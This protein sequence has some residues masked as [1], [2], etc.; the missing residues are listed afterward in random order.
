MKPNEIKN[1]LKNA[2]YKVDGVVCRGFYFDYEI[3]NQ[4]INLLDQYENEIE[5]LKAQIAVYEGW[6]LK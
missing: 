5:R 6:G 1:I 3:V 2:K 4:I